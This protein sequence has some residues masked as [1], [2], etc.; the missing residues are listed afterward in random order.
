MYVLRTPDPGGGTHARQPKPSDRAEL[1]AQPLPLEEVLDRLARVEN[2]EE[3]AM[4]RQRIDEVKRRVTT[5]TTTSGVGGE[6]RVE[7]CINNTHFD[8][9]AQPILQITPAYLGYCWRRGLALQMA[10]MQDGIDGILPVFVGDLDR[11][12]SDDEEPAGQMTYVAWELEHVGGAEGLTSRAMLALLLDLGTSSA[13]A[14][15][16]RDAKGA[17]HLEH[18]HASK[19]ATMQSKAMRAGVGHMRSVFVDLLR[20]M[21][22]E[23]AY[24][25]HNTLTDPL[26]NDSVH[27]TGA[28]SAQQSQRKAEQAEAEEEQ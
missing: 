24:E 12:W 8:V 26:W 10:H 25:L 6:A 13:L 18:V 2:E 20:H 11:A 9:R 16:P 15:G 7:A 17:E 23:P 5:T 4:M 14:A 1:L 28:C 19:E 27:P 21:A 22:D 3:A